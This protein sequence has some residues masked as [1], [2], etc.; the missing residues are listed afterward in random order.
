MVS[1]ALDRKRRFIEVG[2]SFPGVLPDSRAL[3]WL[4][5]DTVLGAVVAL[6][7]FTWLLSLPMW[8]LMCMG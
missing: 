8:G 7:S 5:P 4:V 1:G 6:P 3:S 2:E